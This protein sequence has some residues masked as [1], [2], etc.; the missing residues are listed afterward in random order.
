M[1]LPTHEQ[2]WPLHLKAARGAQ[3]TSDE[4]AVYEAGRSQFER[5]ESAAFVREAAKYDA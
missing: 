2:W 5:E 3:L 1:N 4:Q